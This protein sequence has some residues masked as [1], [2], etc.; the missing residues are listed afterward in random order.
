M[1]AEELKRT[2][3]VCMFDQ[4]GTV[5]DMQGGL[6]EAATPYLRAKGWTGDPNTFVTWWRRTH[7]ENSMI[8]ALLGRARTPYREIGQRSL[9]YVLER[10]GIAHSMDEVRALVAAIERLKP[11]PEVPAA[12]ARLHARYKLAVLSNGDPDMLEA[13]RAHHGIPFDAVIS[14]AIANA[15]K[16]HV[17]TYTKAAEILG[18]RM[19]QVLFVA[20]H[21]FD[22]VGAKSAGMRTAF[23]D[24]RRRPFG[25]TPHQPD[26]I[27]PS[28]TEL[29]ALLA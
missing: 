17:A 10:A 2:I 8:D 3:S 18:V 16:P 28:M 19:E 4:Y 14:V 29:A 9:D 1:D 6:V 15:F 21:A 22:C 26:L 23:I 13:A 24:R 27:V 25:A 12:L 11:F 5:V 20:N 7:Y